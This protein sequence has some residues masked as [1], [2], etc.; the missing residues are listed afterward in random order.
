MN[1]RPGPGCPAPVVGRYKIY[2]LQFAN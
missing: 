1:I 2:L